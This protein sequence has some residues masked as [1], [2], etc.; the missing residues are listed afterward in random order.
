MVRQ[1]NVGVLKDNWGILVRE[2]AME[3]LYWRY[4]TCNIDVWFFLDTVNCNVKRRA[5]IMLDGEQVFKN[6]VE[7]SLISTSPNFLLRPVASEEQDGVGVEP[8]KVKIPPPQFGKYNL[9]KAW[10]LRYI[11]DSTAM[12]FNYLINAYY[13]QT[14]LKIPQHPQPND[15]KSTRCN[16]VTWYP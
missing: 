5:S 14:C 4:C 13:I 12:Y 16:R 3:Q 15:S 10:K 6:G 2:I 7:W 9:H 11:V 8:S 1:L